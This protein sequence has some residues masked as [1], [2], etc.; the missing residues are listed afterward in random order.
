MQMC[1]LQLW[2]GRRRESR[3]GAGLVRQSRTWESGK[4]T[5][6]GGHDNAALAMANKYDAF[7]GWVHDCTPDM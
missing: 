2:Q 1:K 7:L 5:D 3:T 4:L 6:P